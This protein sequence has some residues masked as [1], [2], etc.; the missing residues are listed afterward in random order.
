MARIKAKYLPGWWV[1]KPAT[2][3]TFGSFN[4]RDGELEYIGVVFRSWFEP[5]KILAPGRIIITATKKG[6]SDIWEDFR[7]EYIE[8]A[9]DNKFKPWLEKAEILYLTGALD[10]YCED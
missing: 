8:E 3:A 5:R 7:H 4:Y 9:T 1:A 10:D 6:V 2:D